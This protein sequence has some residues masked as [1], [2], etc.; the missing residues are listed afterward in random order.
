[1]PGVCVVILRVVCTALTALA[2]SHARSPCRQRCAQSPWALTGTTAATGGCTVSACSA[3]G[4]GPLPPR[5]PC[6]T[7]CVWR[8]GGFLGLPVDSHRRAGLPH[9]LQHW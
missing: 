3:R 7:L 6:L 4:S 2:A 1:M 9:Q 8:V 5:S